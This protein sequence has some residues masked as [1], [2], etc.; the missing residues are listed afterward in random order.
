MATAQGEKL[1]R[2]STVADRLDCHRSY[3][4]VLAKKG[5]LSLVK[6]GERGSRITESSLE[7]YI[8][9]LIGELST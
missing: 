1:L 8:A 4:Y 9:S 3:V 6:I 7:Q 5:K 2:V